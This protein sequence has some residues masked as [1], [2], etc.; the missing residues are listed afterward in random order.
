IRD[1]EIATLIHHQ[2]AGLKV[3]M[4]NAGVIMCIIERIAKLAHPLRYFVGLKDLARFVGSQVRKRVTVDVF[5]RDT[6]RGFAADE[7][8]NAY[9]IFMGEL[10]ASSRLALQFVQ[11]PPIMNHYIW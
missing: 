6:S 4:N 11:H 1:F 9:D 7:I 8:V 2:I 5:H 3:P 10:E